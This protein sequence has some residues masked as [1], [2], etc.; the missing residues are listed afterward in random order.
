MGMKVTMIGKVA[1]ILLILHHIR[2]EAVAIDH[3]SLVNVDMMVDVH[4]IVEQAVHRL[5][6]IGLVVIPVLLHLKV[7]DS[8]ARRQVM[9]IVIIK[10]EEVVIMVEYQEPMNQVVILVVMMIIVMA[11]LL[12]LHLRIVDLHTVVGQGNIDVM[13]HMIGET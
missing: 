8:I 13:Y 9:G 12:L 6:M 10:A 1:V 4:M 11:V 5:L 3:Q 7:M 2:M